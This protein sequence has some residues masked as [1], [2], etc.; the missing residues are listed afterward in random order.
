MLLSAIVLAAA[1]LRREAGPVTLFASS[2]MFDEHLN[3]L[4]TN[5]LALITDS[6][7]A[8]PATRRLAADEHWLRPCEW[9][10]V[11]T[12]PTINCSVSAFSHANTE[13]Y[14]LCRTELTPRA[15]HTLDVRDQAGQLLRTQ[16]FAG[17]AFEPPPSW[18]LAAI[19]G[20][21]HELWLFEA[22]AGGRAV[23]IDT[24]QRG[25]TVTGEVR[26]RLPL[27]YGPYG[28]FWLMPSAAFDGDRTF[29]AIINRGDLNGAAPGA[30]LRPGERAPATGYALLTLD[31][32]SNVTRITALKPSDIVERG[33]WA[34]TFVSP[35]RLIGLLDDSSR[36]AIDATTGE[37]TP[38]CG[39]CEPLVGHLPT[40][41]LS[42]RRVDANK[43]SVYI[44]YDPNEQASAPAGW[45]R[46][47]IVYSFDAATGE[48]D[49]PGCALPANLTAGL[50]LAVAGP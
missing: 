12:M 4:P 46:R 3:P 45:A 35:D 48:P 40:L 29:A 49:G 42:P 41:S 2:C 24:R 28:L 14:H 19:G 47:P 20:D 13:L 44:R 38:L 7:A 27:H 25:S 6:S 23:V 1:V 9:S 15:Y 17:G 18:D 39:H 30:R 26:A 32:N 10:P 5:F 8:L 21:G 16:V 43:T 34:M 50:T 36:V 31:V 11:A 22:T 33:V 37:V